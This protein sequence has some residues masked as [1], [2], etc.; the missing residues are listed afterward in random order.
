[1]K[2]GHRYIELFLNSSRDTVPSHGGGPPQYAAPPAPQQG[3]WSDPRGQVSVNIKIC[4]LI[5]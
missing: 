1:M 3:S 4:A 2:T 5:S